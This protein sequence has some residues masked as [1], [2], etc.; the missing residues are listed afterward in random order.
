MPMPS[1]SDQASA[2]RGRYLTGMT[3]L[4]IDCHTPFD[5]SM[6]A[7][8]QTKFFIGSRTFANTDLGLMNPPYPAMI[9]SRN[10]TSDATGLG[11]F[12]LTDIKNA[13]SLGKDPMGDAVCAATHGNIISPYAGLAA[14]DLN[15]IANYIKSLPPIVNDTGTNCQGLSGPVTVA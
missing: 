9:N 10:L 8:D 3:G 1:Y 14:D 12:S 7:L 15:D 4:C 2:T 6:V 5:A 13:V 11:T